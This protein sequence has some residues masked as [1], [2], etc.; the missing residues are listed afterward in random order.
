VYQIQKNTAMIEGVMH[1]VRSARL[2]SADDFAD[3]R[4]K[5]RIDTLFEV[6]PWSIAVNANSILNN[7]PTHTDHDYD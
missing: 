3:R 6:Q 5:F 7:P 2:V 4:Q 1:N